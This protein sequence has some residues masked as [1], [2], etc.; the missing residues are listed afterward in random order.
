MAHMVGG[1]V[2]RLGSFPG[3]EGEGLGL[4][5]ED[6]NAPCVARIVYLPGVDAAA[7]E[8]LERE[9]ARAA[10]ALYHP[11]VQPPLGL[12]EVD[13]RLAMAVAHADGET[14]AEI[15]A[16]GGRLSPSIAARIVRDACIAVQF[17]HEEGQEHGPILHGWLRPSNLLVCRS[18]VTLVSGF[19]VGLSRSAADLMPWQS[20]EQVLGGPRAAS[21]A[22]D[23]H[24][25]GLVLHACLAGE[26]PFERE[27]DPDVAILSRAAPLLEPL[28]VSSA[29]AAVVR[30]ALA[31][32]APDRFASPL[33]L[34]RAIEAAVPDLA[35]PATVAAWSESLFP[36]GMGMRVLR[37]RAVEGA[38][39]AAAREAARRPEQAG[40]PIPLPEP[41]IE[42]VESPRV[43]RAEP[44]ASEPRV[45]RRPPPW[46]RFRPAP[47]PA[48]EAPAARLH[49]TLTV[50]L[51]SHPTPTL[52]VVTRPVAVR[53]VAARPAPMRPARRGEVTANDGA[54]DEVV[55]GEFSLAAPPFP[56]PVK[57]VDPVDAIEIDVVLSDP[58]PPLRLPVPPRPLAGGVQAI[59]RMDVRSGSQNAVAGVAAMAL[60]QLRGWP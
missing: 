33:E 20:P 12:D 54:A 27:P 57:V 7:R 26:N 35:S 53:P 56:H 32:K 15:L 23:V 51:A 40:H 18:G 30:R 48:R 17:A 49:P 58:P 38:R 34:A 4:F 45:G 24:G 60:A 21:R 13:G 50:P 55:I 11:Y 59:S 29:L 2:V 10:E 37:Q 19:G 1:R 14:L 41:R 46:L 31:V 5:L 44:P 36:A 9:V 28:G 3:R 6:G 8:G 39:T 16:V 52:P 22:S 43:E 42:A 47:N 25:L